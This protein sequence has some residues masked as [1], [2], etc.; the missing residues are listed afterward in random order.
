MPKTSD[1]S[2]GAGDDGHIA[3][4][5]PTGAPRPAPSGAPICAKKTLKPGK[6][7]K[8][9][10]Q[11][12]WVASSVTSA[13]GLVVGTAAIT[14]IA[15]NQISTGQACREGKEKSRISIYTSFREGQV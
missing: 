14:S 5:P 11:K 6:P 3:Y 9:A 13:G 4:R 7:D 12:E 1:R 8:P 10:A 15:T 2:D